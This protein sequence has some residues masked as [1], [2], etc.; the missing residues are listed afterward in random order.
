M[1]IR[2]VTP[3]DLNTWAEMRFAL[4]PDSLEE[5]ATEL[6]RYFNGE[7]FDIDFAFVVETPEERLAG[8][9]EVNLRD[10]AEGSTQSP[11]PYLEAWYV[12]PEYQ[13][14]GYGQSLLQFFEQ[15]AKNKGF[16]EIAS[17]TTPDNVRSIELHKQYGFKETERVVCFVK[18]VVGD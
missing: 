2:P 5:H 11:I 8:F 6:R 9:I 10:Y 15:W 7:Q 16:K 13:H 17:D 1:K 4:W 12:K 18:S 3:A 14:Q